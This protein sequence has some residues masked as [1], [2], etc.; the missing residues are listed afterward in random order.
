ML[1]RW[2]YQQPDQCIF[3]VERVTAQGGE[4]P[5]AVEKALVEDLF[6]PAEFKSL[7]SE[8]AKES[9][10]VGDLI[11]E[12][13]EPSPLYNK[14]AIPFLGETPIFEE[15]LKIVARG[16]IVLNVSGTW[17]GRLQS[18]QVMRKR[19]ALFVPRHSVPGRRCD[20]SNLGY[21]QR[22]AGRPLRAQ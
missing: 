5:T 18:I 10:L 4:I 9:C 20:K 2:N 7:V 15:I 11:D 19:C 12:L 21:R 1:R 14:D 6:D 13:T 22:L 17:V 8:R 3:D 16:K